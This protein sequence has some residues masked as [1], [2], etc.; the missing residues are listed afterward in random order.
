LT[1]KL[2]ADHSGAAADVAFRDVSRCGGECG[3]DVRG[4]HTL[5]TDVVEEAVERL[6]DDG[7]RPGVLV[8]RP[9]GDRIAHD[10]DAEGVRDADRRRQQP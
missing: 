8:G 1:R 6:A 3:V 10:T 7:Q 5:R 9:R 4:G 2:V